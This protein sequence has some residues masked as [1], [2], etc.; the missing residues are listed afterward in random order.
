MS[1][2][3]F[4]YEFASTYSYP[5]AMR[6]EAVATQRGIAVCWQPFLL[7]PIFRDEGWSTSPFNLQEAKGR[8]M[9]RD[10]ERTCA[11]SGLPPITRPTTF[12]Q[13]SL[14]AARVALS[15]P[16]DGTRAEF[17][18]RVYQRQFANGQQIADPQVLSS[19][20][21]E[22]GLSAQAELERAARP[23]NKERLRQQV[24]NAR[25]RGIFG[26]PSFLTQDGELFWGNDR[27]EEALDWQV[28]HA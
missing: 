17:S 20:L 22:L 15:L 2:I 19:A 1:E 27:L 6:I 8:Y 5:A 18:R 9:W 12:P 4:W 21:A 10:L 11:A 28:A 23:N 16:D 24:E 26:A 3:E 7:G 14:Q 13:N 25:Q